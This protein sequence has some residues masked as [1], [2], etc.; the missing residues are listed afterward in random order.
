MSEGKR[1]NGQ[2]SQEA[3]EMIQARE[4]GIKMAWTKAAVVQ[5][6]FKGDPTEL[7]NLM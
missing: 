4:D 6:D 1:R 7:S 2:T 5:F 3:I